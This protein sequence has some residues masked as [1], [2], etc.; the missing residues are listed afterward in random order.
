MA[1]QFKRA[2]RH[3]VKLK[4][5]IDG[6]SG[7]GK[8][9]GALAIAAGITNNGRIAV[10][11]S[12]NGSASLY[13][14]RYAFD[15]VEIPD[16]EPKTYEAIIDLAVA[17]GYEALIIDSL[18]HAWRTVLD[19]KDDYD[20]ANP[21]SNTWTNWRIFGPRWEKLMAHILA[22]PIHIIATMRSKQAYEQVEQNGRKS[23]VKLGLQPQVR[24][25][26]EYEFSLVF[27]VNQAHRAEATKDRTNLFTDTTGTPR[28]VDLR[29]PAIHAELVA[30]MQSG[31]PL[32]PSPATPAVPAIVPAMHGFAC[33]EAVIA[34]MQLVAHP[35]I[36]EATRD[37]IA[38]KLDAGSP[39]AFDVAK[40]TRQLTK[41]IAAAH[42]SASE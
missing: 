16:A 22:A 34:M 9:E 31:G 5:G 8:T 20:R 12:E 36:P 33:E 24:E 17:E 13:S 27:S 35:A 14:D 6:P 21:K 28:L 15:T 30:W 10:A 26:A 38:A 25:G 4:M 29:L 19:A 41:H 37:A 39:L 42:A 32:A 7:S 18:S 11:D 23:I 1:M 2:T 3:S 40:W